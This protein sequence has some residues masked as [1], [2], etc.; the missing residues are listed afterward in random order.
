MNRFVSISLGMVLIL[1]ACGARK[2]TPDLPATTAIGTHPAQNTQPAAPEAGLNPISEPLTMDSSSK[3]ILQKMQASSATWQTIFVDGIITWYSPG[4][5]NTPQQVIHE[6]DWVDYANHRFRVLL[7]PAGGAAN[8][9]KTCDGSTILSIDLKSGQSQSSPLPEF[10]QNPMPVAG[11]DILWGQI[12]TPLAEIALTANYAASEGTYDKQGIETVARR[13]TLVV[14]W[15]HTGNSL[16]SYRAWLDVET[17]VILKFQD[18]GKGG[19]KTLEGERVV[20]QV[21]Y[22]EN[23]ADTLFGL[24]GTMPQFG[25]INGNSLPPVAPTPPP[26]DWV[27]PLGQVYFFIND[28]K[29]ENGTIKLV[30]LPGSC[31]IG[32]NACPQ[33]ETIPTPFPL[34]F[35]LT[36]L[37]WSPDK[38]KAAYAFPTSSDGNKTE[39]FIFDPVQ[40]AWT[41]LVKFN[42]IDPP[43]WSPDGNWMAFRVQDGLGGDDTYVI[44]SDGTGLTNL[45]GSGKLPSENRPYIADG[46]ISGSVILHSAMPGMEGFVYQ[47]SPADGS[48]KSLFGSKIIKSQFFPSPDGADLAFFEYSDNNPKRALELVDIN[49]TV[50]RE[51]FVFRDGSVYPV[52][53]SPDGIKIA[54]LYYSDSPQMGQDVYLVNRDG[55]GL[56]QVYHGMQISTLAFSPDGKNLLIQNDEAIGS[57]IFVVNLATLDQH[58]IQAPD[59]R[60]DW[61][62]LA[63]SWRP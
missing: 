11:Q 63:P 22:G 17:G 48:V 62:W 18:F 36:P 13:Q 8:S 16:P 9:F 35:S 55:T 19:S 28:N 4:G 50:T 12:G 21:V 5:G 42:N 47:I 54:F 49:G 51:L 31:V 53:W 20:K 27:D 25:D 59:L 56:S 14:D 33:P 46:W 2:T 60:L 26:S 29:N 24:P 1:S 52:V 45:T 30:R 41:S 57:H 38:K 37:V 61:S 58:I 34:N 32:Q 15:T 23:F 10:A 7:G 39:L 40:N 43:M 3:A 44:H 6:E